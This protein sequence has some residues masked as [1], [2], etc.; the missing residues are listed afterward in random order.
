M[1]RILIGPFN[2]I[3]GMMVV[4]LIQG[5]LEMAALQSAKILLLPSK[6]EIIFVT[7]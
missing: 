2:I 5:S 6:C 4:R 1:L 3:I 7:L